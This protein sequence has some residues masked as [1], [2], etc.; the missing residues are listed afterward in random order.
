MYFTLAELTVHEC[1]E[2]TNKLIRCF[3]IL[4]KGQHVA[5]DL[6][7]FKEELLQKVSEHEN[8]VDRAVAKRE[9]IAVFR[10]PN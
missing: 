3:H 5:A 6:A 7:T 10:S 4:E 2:T 9:D 1:A 8:D